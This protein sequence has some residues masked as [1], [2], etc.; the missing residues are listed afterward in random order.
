MSYNVSVQK[1]AAG[2][3]PLTT[4]SHRPSSGR[5]LSSVFVVKAMPSPVPTGNSPLRAIEAREYGLISA[6]PIFGRAVHAL[7][8]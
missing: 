6:V 4:T 8:R 3:T 2:V 5:L 1:R 7:T